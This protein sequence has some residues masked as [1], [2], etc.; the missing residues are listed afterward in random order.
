MTE[1]KMNRPNSLFYIPSINKFA[2]NDWCIVHTLNRLFNTWQ[3]DNWK[4]NR[5][6][7]SMVARDGKVW[8]LYYL[9]E[10]E[11]VDILGLIDWNQ[12]FGIKMDR[13]TY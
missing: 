6:N 8:H 2:D 13:I 10:D 11:E 5:R 12:S 9:D 4:R 7:S 3:L 1:E